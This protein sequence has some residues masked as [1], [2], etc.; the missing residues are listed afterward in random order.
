MAT[1]TTQATLDQQYLDRQNDL[2]DRVKNIADKPYQA[3]TGETVAQFNPDQ[4]NLMGRVRERFNNANPS[5]YQGALDKTINEAPRYI[6]NRSFLNMNVEDYMNPY[7]DQVIDRTFR[8]IDRQTDATRQKVRDDA[9]A[10]KAFGNSRRDIMEGVVVAEGERNKLDAAANLYKDAYLSG[11]N[12]MQAD[13]ANALGIDQANQDYQTDYLNQLQKSAAL[14]MD[15]YR[16]A[17]TTFGGVGDALQT[18]S[19]LRLDQDVEEFYRQQGYDEKQARMLAD[20]LYGQRVETENNTEVSG[21]PRAKGPSRAQSALSGAA[22]GYMI[23]GPVGA[24]AGAI[25]GGLF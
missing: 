13:V 10:K 3:Y 24:V 6:Q 20:I 2:F 8:N 4:I 1:K 11:Q 5:L 16:D 19:Q 12:M 21:V 18:N 14:G 9:I 17:R 15:D 25:L 22:T 7:V 23:G